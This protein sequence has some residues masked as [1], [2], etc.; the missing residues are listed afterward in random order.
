[1]RQ[2]ELVLMID[3]EADQE[4]VDAVIERVR[5]IANDHGGE[6]VS[7]NNWG[8]R[9]LAYKIGSHTE[10]N[11]HLTNI[12][13]ENDGTKVLENNLKLADDVIRHLLVRTED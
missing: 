13:M 7:E 10:A 6:I 9:K 1:M 5:K 11:Y 4:R 8:K 2:Y 12:R 3:P